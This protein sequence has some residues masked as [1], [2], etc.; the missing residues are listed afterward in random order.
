[1]ELIIKIKAGEQKQIH[2]DPPSIHF[3]PFKIKTILF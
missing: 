1:M 3:L 2:A